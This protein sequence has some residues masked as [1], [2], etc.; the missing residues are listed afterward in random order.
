M[1]GT[2]KILIMLVIAVAIATTANIALVSARFDSQNMP[3]VENKQVDSDRLEQTILNMLNKSIDTL[4]DIENK[5]ENNSKISNET[6]QI[7]IDAL[8]KV[9]KGLVNY[10]SEVEAATTIDELKTINQEIVQYVKDNKD[11]IKENIKSAIIDVS[12]QAVVKIEEFKKKVEQMLKVLK[13]TC[14]SEIETIN[15][16]EAQLEQLQNKLNDIKQAIQLKDTMTIKQEMKEINELSK[17]IADNLRKLEM[18]CL[19]KE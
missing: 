5:I 3:E 9:E 19:S 16:I 1:F 12:E 10:E 8:N 6:K 17:D 14:P 4:N 15:E 2:K 18:A 11:V 7:I 13:V